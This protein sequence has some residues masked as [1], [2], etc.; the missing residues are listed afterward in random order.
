MWRL[1]EE[2]MCCEEMIAGQWDGRQNLKDVKQARLC[3]TQVSEVALRLKLLCR[4]N[5][6][7][8]I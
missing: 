1:E 5:Y 3:L 6:N 4:M 2:L 8:F 7:P